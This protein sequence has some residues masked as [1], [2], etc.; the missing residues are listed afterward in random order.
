M[1]QQNV[2]IVK[3]N[4][5]AFA[6]RGL[7][8][9]ME[10]FADDVEYRAPEGSLDDVGTI[11]GK[12]ALR[13]WLQQWMDAFEGFWFE[14]VEFIDAGEDRVVVVERF[15]GRARISGIETEQTQALVSTIRDGKIVRC[16]EFMT[17]REALEAVGLS[18]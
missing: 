11:H 8:A 14:P 13:A 5:D 17:R 18:E 12:T 10:Q 15:G 1:S 4:Y 2:E 9:W 7:D 3:A 16:R 6:L